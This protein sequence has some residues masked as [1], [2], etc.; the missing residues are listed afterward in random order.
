MKWKMKMCRLMRQTDV[1]VVEGDNYG[2]AEAAAIEAACALKETAWSEPNVESI[3]VEKCDT[4]KDS[5]A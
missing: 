1:V 5:Q 3:K 4:V 2:E